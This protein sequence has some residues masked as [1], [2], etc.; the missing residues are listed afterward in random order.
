MR[1]AVCGIG[2]TLPRPDEVI[3]LMSV[4]SYSPEV[5]TDE[6][7]AALEWLALAAM[8]TISR[9]EQDR[10]RTVLYAVFPDLDTAAITSLADLIG[11]VWVRLGDIRN[12]IADLAVRPEI[13][14]DRSLSAEAARLI[15]LCEDLQIETAD[16]TRSTDTDDASERPVLTRRE[17]EIV[18]LIA[19]DRSNREI[20]RALH[21][22]EKTIKAHVT[23]I[24]RKYNATQRSAV[25]WQVRAWSAK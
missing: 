15:A 13:A 5:F 3:G 24:L 18:R 25:A 8:L 17:G 16:A 23:S 4:Q 2:R 14:T 9:D 21:L 20:A 19:Q 1:C 10:D 7:A 11:H 6:H 22:S 12:G